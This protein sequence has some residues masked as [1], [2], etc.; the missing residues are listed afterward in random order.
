MAFSLAWSAGFLLLQMAV[1]V[2]HFP[3][4]LALLRARTDG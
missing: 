3:R 4:M 1:A 2:A